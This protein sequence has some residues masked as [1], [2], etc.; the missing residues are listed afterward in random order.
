M[1]NHDTAFNLMDEITNGI[2][3]TYNLPGLDKITKKSIEYSLSDFPNI[4]G[5]YKNAE[6]SLKIRSKDNSLYL[7]DDKFKSEK[8]LYLGANRR[9]FVL[10][11]AFEVEYLSQSNKIKIYFQGVSHDFD[12]LIKTDK[13]AGDDNE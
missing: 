6:Y 3:D 10:E 9:F 13:S 4:S 8:K 5:A 11:E 7:Y 1:I 12:T 2:A